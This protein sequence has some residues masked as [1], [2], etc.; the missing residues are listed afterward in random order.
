MFGL[1]WD[2]AKGVREHAMANPYKFQRREPPKPQTI[3]ER[4]MG[5]YPPRE[6]RGD[7]RPIRGSVQVL[8]DGSVGGTP[9]PLPVALMSALR[10]SP[11]EP[12]AYLQ[13]NTNRDK[14][15]RLVRAKRFIAKERI[16]MLQTDKPR[17]REAALSLRWKP[18]DQFLNK[19]SPPS[20]YLGG[21]TRVFER[22]IA[23]PKD[24]S[25]SMQ[26]IRTLESRWPK[27]PLPNFSEVSSALL[28]RPKTL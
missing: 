6:A 26:P 27:T 16:T 23:Y 13:S 10:D 25:V 15:E 3:L 11:M 21:F 14:S 5:L 1:V 19:P 24:T 12:K 4:F 9:V 22:N 28:A 17:A 20:P 18:R 8:P 7:K 2:K